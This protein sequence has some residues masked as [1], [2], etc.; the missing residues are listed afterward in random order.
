MQNIYPSLRYKDASAAIDWL[1][2]AFGFERKA[3][4]EGEKGI[5]EH[6]EL[7]Y[8]G[9]LI[10]LGSERP[11]DLKNGFGL[12]GGQGW[13]YVVVDDPDA[14]YERAKGAGAEII[15]ELGNQDYG[16]R[17]YSARD[18]EGN[19]WSFG[20]YNPTAQGEESTSGAAASG[21]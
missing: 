1:C 14:H 3:V 8:Q 10:M 13:L 9:G 16:S 5:V 20:T 4:Y 19:I 12:R 11:S 6:A 7:S 2:R 21:G 18:P 15:R 17:D